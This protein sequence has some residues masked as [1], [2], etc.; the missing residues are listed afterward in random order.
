M[1]MGAT[2]DPWAR[3]WFLAPNFEVDESI[4]LRYDRARRCV[5]SLICFDDGWEFEPDE[6]VDYISEP[7]TES[8]DIPPELYGEFTRL[9]GADQLYPD[10]LFTRMAVFFSDMFE[11]LPVEQARELAWDD[12]WH[13]GPSPTS[14]W[15]PVDLGNGLDPFTVRALSPEEPQP[16]PDLLTVRSAVGPDG[17]GYLANLGEIQWFMHARTFALGPLMSRDKLAEFEIGDGVDLDEI[18]QSVGDELRRMMRFLGGPR[19]MS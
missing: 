15:R 7:D 10:E 11:V 13:R 2:G 1:A 14:V 3:I 19:P 4:R 5:D 17:A 9:C 8:K 12:H 16:Q 6:E 18:E